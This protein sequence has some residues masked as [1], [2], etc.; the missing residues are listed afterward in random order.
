MYHLRS[1][2]PITTS[3]GG[4]QDTAFGGKEKLRQRMNET[5]SFPIKSEKGLFFLWDYIFWLYSIN[6]NN[7]YQCLT[8][9]LL[10]HI[11]R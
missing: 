4:Y 3:A 7:I 2:Q 5:F 8:G 10:A 1:A 6:Q 9:V 11:F